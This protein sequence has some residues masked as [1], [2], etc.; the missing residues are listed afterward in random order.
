[1]FTPNPIAD[2]V[3]LSLIHEKQGLLKSLLRRKTNENIHSLSSRD[4][5]LL[6]AIAD[7]RA[8]AD[9]LGEEVEIGEDRIFLSHRLAAAIDAKAADVLGLPP[10]VD[11]AFRTDVEGFPGQSQFRLRFDWCPARVQY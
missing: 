2:G 10:L 4:R 6:F 7:L 3:E 1:M 8:Y 11:L 5:D 9:E